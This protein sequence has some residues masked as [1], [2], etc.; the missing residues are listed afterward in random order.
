MAK[1]EAEGVQ[2]DVPPTSQVDLK[3]RLEQDGVAGEHPLDSDDD[4]VN[5]TKQRDLFAVEGNDTDHYIGVSEEYRT[6]AN[7]TE[8]PYPFEGAEGDEV[9]RQMDVYAVGKPVV[10]ETEHTKGGGSTYETVTTHE[11]GGATQP[12]VV[13]REKV[14]KEAESQDQDKQPSTP[15]TAPTTRSTGTSGKNS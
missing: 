12:D 4:S 1:K 15:Q 14:Y 11:S 6:Y 9:K 13:D 5:P 7:D 8:K 2:L 10:A 3:R